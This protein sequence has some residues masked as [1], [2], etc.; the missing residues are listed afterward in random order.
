MDALVSELEPEFLAWRASVDPDDPDDEA[1]TARWLTMLPA[2]DA[3]LVAAAG[4]RAVAASV[5]EAL[6]D[7]RGYLRDAALLS[8]PWEHLPPD[9]RCPVRAWFGEDDDRSGVGAAA[10]L[11]AGFADVE[12]VVRPATSHLATLVAH[13]P[14]VLTVLRDELGS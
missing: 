2:P 8:R 1:L 14:E 12:V 7:P 3:P 6:R 9:V 13:W 5:R 10:G 4:P 11:V